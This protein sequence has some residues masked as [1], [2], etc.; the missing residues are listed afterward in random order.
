MQALNR[1]RT[2]PDPAPWLLQ[3]LFV[4][5]AEPTVNWIGT[6]LFLFGGA[7]VPLFASL[8]APRAACLTSF[9]T[10]RASFLTPFCAARASFLRVCP[11]R[12]CWIA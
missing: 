4:R 1:H 3:R 5:S 9:C 2:K 11:E 8:C 6:L 12:S 7:V 10:S